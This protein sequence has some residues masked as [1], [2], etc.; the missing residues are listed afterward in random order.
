MPGYQAFSFIRRAS[1]A[2][3]NL[4]FCCF[5]ENVG[6][7]SFFL[8]GSLFVNFLRGLLEV[9]L[10]YTRQFIFCLFLLE[11]ECQFSEPT[12]QQQFV[13]G[14]VVPAKD[15]CTVCARS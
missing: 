9:Y 3:A 15:F 2:T 13:R 14:R 8:F 11:K 7:I 6:V 12:E 1:A 10:Y 5:T 4:F